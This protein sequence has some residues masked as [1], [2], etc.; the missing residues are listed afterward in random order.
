[1]LQTHA[2][3]AGPRKFYLVAQFLEEFGGVEVHPAHQ[4]GEGHFAE[5]ELSLDFIEIDADL[6]EAFGE[7]R[8]GFL[9]LREGFGPGEGAA[10]VAVVV[11]EDRGFGARVPVEVVHI[12]IDG[13]GG[14]AV[15]GPDAGRLAVEAPDLVIDRDGLAAVQVLFRQ[16]AR[17]DAVVVHLAVAVAVVDLQGFVQ[18]RRDGGAVGTAVDDVRG[19]AV[20]VALEDEYLREGIPGDVLG[21]LPGAQKR[22]QQVAQALFRHIVAHGDLVREGRPGRGVAPTHQPLDFLV[23]VARMVEVELCSEALFPCALRHPFIAVVQF[24]FVPFAAQEAADF[25]ALSGLQAHE[26]EDRRGDAAG[27]DDAPHLR[28]GAF[29]RKEAVEGEPANQDYGGDDRP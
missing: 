17:G 25:A 2:A 18:G 24:P 11:G 12:D 8:G 9:H 4:G 23:E 7:L 6:G 14:A 19:A 13:V 1:M 22:D 15:A 27:K 3:K 20:V 16:D 21:A 26:R 10:A 28:P 29:Q 5:V